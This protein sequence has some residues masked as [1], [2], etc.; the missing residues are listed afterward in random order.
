V[1]LPT[2]AVGT[3]RRYAKKNPKLRTLI[4]IVIH[5]FTISMVSFVSIPWDV[6]CL[7]SNYLLLSEEQN[8][9]VFRFT[10]AWR[11]LLNTN[12]ANF[13]EWKKRSQ[14]VVLRLSY[15][16]KNISSSQFRARILRTIV[17]PLHQ[18]E[19]CISPWKYTDYFHKLETAKG[20]NELKS[21]VITDCKVTP[22]PFK[23]EEMFLHNCSV[24]D[25]ERFPPLKKLSLSYC[26]TGDDYT[27]VVDAASLQGISDEASF[28]CMD[29]E[30]YR[31]LA[32]LKSI[33]VGNT[34]SIFDVSCFRNLQKVHFQSCP[35][36]IDVSGLKNVHDLSL[37]DCDG[38][39]DVSS[40]GKVHHLVLSECKNVSDVSAL[41]NVHILNLDWCSQ[42][43]DV[44]MLKNVY[45]LHLCGFEGDDLTG[46]ENLRKLFMTYARNVEDISM[47]K[48]LNI[49]DIDHCPGISHFAGLNKLRTI[50]I[51]VSS[52]LS[53]LAMLFK[54][55]SGF[56]VF[57]GLTKLSAVRVFIEED[58]QAPSPF[59][60]KV[61]LSFKYLRTLRSLTLD[62][63]HFQRL[64][65]FF[66]QLKS[67]HIL[68]CSCLESLPEL[69]DLEELIIRECW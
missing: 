28:N 6:L 66:L 21:L 27:A 41:G 26:T 29:L 20:M 2:F 44:S 58:D 37:I 64:P 33:S 19:L 47:L 17:D 52:T 1:A 55:H 57:S 14:V 34:D 7:L 48:N 39:I 12:Q 53:E 25:L 36:I 51:G 65:L 42:V 11:N 45:E 60:M 13:G 23:M 9:Q 62:N 30:N 54:V 5:Y 49:L 67:L 15:A 68:H 3:S 43:R 16:K 22:L 35:N 69:P 8:K 4:I 10:S 38:V 50:K 18:L 32:H 46:L 61:T 24:A 63:C 56:E 40:L 31:V 59:L